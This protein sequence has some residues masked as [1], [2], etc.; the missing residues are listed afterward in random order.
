[1][2]KFNFNEDYFN[3]INTEDKAYFLGLLYADGSNYNNVI[4]LG[5]Q[6]KDKYILEL[7]KKYIEYE[8]NLYFRKSKNIKHSNQCRLDLRSI[9][10]SNKLSEIGC[11]PKKSLILTFPDKAIIPEIMINH[12]I[13]GYFDGDGSIYFSKVN[14]Y[15]Y[16][17]FSIVGTKNFCENLIKIFKT[18]CNI[19]TFYLEKLGENTFKVRT[20]SQKSCI[21]LYH[22][23]Y[24]NA[25]IFLYRK[26]EL[27]LN[28]RTNRISAKKENN[29]FN[30]KKLICN[31]TGIIFNNREEA[32]KYFN[33]SKT[34]IGKY[35]GK[36]KLKKA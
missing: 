24:D 8:G 32:A 27:F 7:F 28:I 25:T 29:H 14:N 35:I 23:L 21:A 22:Y 6:E 20:G 36:N 10:L 1:M 12:F 34:T 33:V 17:N 26:K 31:E 15:Y 4:S 11:V 2:R 5:L 19:K 9:I 3:E 18:N 13:R 16:P 30:M